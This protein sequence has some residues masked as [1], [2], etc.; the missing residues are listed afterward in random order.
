MWLILHWFSISFLTFIYSKYSLLTK[1]YWQNLSDI[2][3]APDSHFFNMRN[4]I[5]S[6]SFTRETIFLK[7]LRERK[8]LENP[9]NDF[10]SI[11][12]LC[13]KIRGLSR[14]AHKRKFLQKS[15]KA[16][17][18]GNWKQYPQYR[19]KKKIPWRIRKQVK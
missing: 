14:H 5:Q 11:D 9:W 2:K 7:V 10:Q 4:D 16:Q 18:S 6:F 13:G 19:W 8:S 17:F 12:N 1:S 15:S 3:C